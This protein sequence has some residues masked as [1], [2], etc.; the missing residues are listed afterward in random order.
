MDKNTTIKSLKTELDMLNVII[1]KKI[2][3]GHSYVAES[4]RHKFVVS[5]LAQLQ[6]SSRVSSSWLVR[7]FATF[8]I[9]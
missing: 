2:L 5:R 8:S 3:R 1:D 9:I 6:K 4:R 7:P